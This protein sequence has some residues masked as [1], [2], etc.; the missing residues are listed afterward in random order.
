MGL[1][2]SK[3]PLER[4]NTVARRT[5]R[6]TIHT[7]KA[8]VDKVF[9]NIKR[10][11]G[12]NNDEDYQALH[13]EIEHLR[14]ELIKKS[15]ELQPQIRHIYDST[16]K[17]IEE[18]FAAL[19][20]KLKENQEKAI[21]KEREREEKEEK[22]KEKKKNKDEEVTSEN[23]DV[24]VE[25]V[26]DEA[27][28]EADNLAESTEKRQ[29]VELKFVHVIPGEVTQADI[30]SNN[31]NVVKTAEEKR[32]SILKHGVAVMPGAMM[33]EIAA[34]TS[35]T[36]TI[37]EPHVEHNSE[38]INARINEII[39]TL[40]ST[41][42]QIA[43][44]VGKK[45]GTQYNRI[46]DKLNQNMTTLNSFSPSDDYTIE[47][48]KICMNYV[49]SCLN[50]LEEKAVEDEK[51]QDDDVFLP[52]KTSPVISPVMSPTM[53][54]TLSPSLSPIDARNQFERLSKTTAI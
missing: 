5:Q 30:H 36:V 27:T 6:R 13:S 31:N 3:S 39:E 19:E 32:K 16:L 10:F 45:H 53:S 15:R 8:R 9:P 46:K 38:K 33:N 52:A 41:E 54:P 34:R 26:E 35:N 18:A 1:S 24:E 29:T 50:F 7:I 43:D 49:I 12:V 4:R 48:V 20:D 47:Q 44:F 22:K 23:N 40:Q 21:K 51:T 25:E 17:R 37:Q 42:Y 11:K 14:I 28:N 2:V